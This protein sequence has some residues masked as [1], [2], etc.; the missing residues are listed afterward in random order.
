LNVSTNP[1][2][3][4]VMDKKLHTFYSL[5]SVTQEAKWGIEVFW[6]W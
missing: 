3:I 4:Q 1:E 2:D 5:L 6:M